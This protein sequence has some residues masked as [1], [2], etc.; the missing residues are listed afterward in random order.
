MFQKCIVTV[1]FSSLDLPVHS[2]LFSCFECFLLKYGKVH[3]NLCVFKM[4]VYHNF[5][6]QQ[7]KQ[8]KGSVVFMH[9][10]PAWSSLGKTTG[11]IETLFHFVSDMFEQI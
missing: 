3:V 8:S 2:D 11:I 7:K 4:S 1:T 10:E 6:N 5:R 9:N